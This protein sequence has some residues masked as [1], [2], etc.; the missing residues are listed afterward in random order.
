MFDS[1]GSKM[2]YGGK[3]TKVLSAGENELNQKL[4]NILFVVLS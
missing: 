2:F 4:V 3:L 1:E